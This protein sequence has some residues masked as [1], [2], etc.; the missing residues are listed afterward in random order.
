MV[1]A[2]PAVEVVVSEVVRPVVSEV[3]RLSVRLSEVPRVTVVVLARPL[4]ELCPALNR[5]KLWPRLWDR[6]RETLSA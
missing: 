5:L 4:P 2:L 3:E 1:E 6:D